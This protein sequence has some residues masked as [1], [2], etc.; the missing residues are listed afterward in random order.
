MPSAEHKYGL[1]SLLLLVSLTDTKT[2]LLGLR[3]MAT[4]STQ[5]R[6]TPQN[7]HPPQGWG[8]RHNKDVTV[9]LSFQC[10]HNGSWSTTKPWKNTN[11]SKK[12]PQSKHACVRKALAKTCGKAQLASCQQKV[13]SSPAQSRLR[14]R[15]EA[16]LPWFLFP[17]FQSPWLLAAMSNLPC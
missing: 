7:L 3:V 11:K 17:S 6:I 16:S 4:S 9:P 15:W 13:P 5:N 14:R 2:A 12:Q 1:W 8:P 10:K